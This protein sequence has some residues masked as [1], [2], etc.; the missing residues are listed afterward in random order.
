MIRVGIL[1]PRELYRSGLKCLLAGSQDLAVVLELRSE[2][3][4]L[5]RVAGFDLDVLLVDLSEGLLSAVRRLT[6]EHPGQNLL[7]LTDR[8]AETELEMLVRL[9][10]R[11][12]VSRNNSA[13]ELIR[14]V[15]AVGQGQSFFCPE[16]SASLASAV[17]LGRRDSGELSAREQLI[18]DHTA[19][20]LT[21][22]EIAGV[23]CLSPRT[24]EALRSSIM[25]KLSCRN[26][27][28]ALQKARQKGLLVD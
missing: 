14:A 4:A 7:V 2:L 15:R 24:V 16:C 13:P 27:M 26:V 18:L 25:R 28:E 11:G 12:F 20:G 17:N 6:H 9:G 10:V 8:P 23:L 19:R 3:E 22:K 21:I 1:Q 5:E